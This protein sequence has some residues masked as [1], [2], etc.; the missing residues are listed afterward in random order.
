MFERSIVQYQGSPFDGTGEDMRVV[1]YALILP[2]V[3]SQCS[4]HSNSVSFF[5]S[6]E[7]G[8][9]PLDTLT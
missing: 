9:H 6:L 8:W 7:N 2:N 1:M 5:M 4:S 3:F